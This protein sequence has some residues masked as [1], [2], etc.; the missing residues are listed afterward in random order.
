MQSDV[1]LILPVLLVNLWF[2][3]LFATSNDSRILKFLFRSRKKLILIDAILSLHCD[4]NKKIIPVKHVLLMYLRR[5]TPEAIHYLTVL[6]LLIHKNC[7]FVEFERHTER[8][9]ENLRP[10]LANIF[11]K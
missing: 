3:R 5:F 1:R 8:S 6:F 4:I 10:L 9:N 11:Q 7:R 2:T